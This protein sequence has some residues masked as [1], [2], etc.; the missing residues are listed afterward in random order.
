MAVKQVKA[1]ETRKIELVNPRGRYMMGNTMFVGSKHYTVNA[2]TAAYLLDQETHSG[3]PVFKIVVPGEKK[4]VPGKRRAPEDMVPPPAL[5]E[6][7]VKEDELEEVAEIEE[8]DE[9]QV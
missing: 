6:I 5:D 1:D 7:Q 2:K 9:I 4:K 8:G 3:K